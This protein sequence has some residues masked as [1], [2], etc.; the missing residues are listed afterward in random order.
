LIFRKITMLGLNDIVTHIPFLPFDKLIQIALASDVFVA[1]SVT[2]ADG[3]AEGTPFVLQQLMA[4]GMPVIATAH[5]DIP[6]IFG[7]HD[8]LLVPE[9]DSDAIATR[10]QEYAENPQ[11][12]LV[13]GTVL[14]ERIR[15]A[16]DVRVCASRLS[17][18]YDALLAR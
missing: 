3:D 18:V 17:E 5:S 12:L 1:P 16:F 4:T 7:E 2:A 9:R 6:Y 14:Q 11:R 10:L 13:D 15:T 8:N